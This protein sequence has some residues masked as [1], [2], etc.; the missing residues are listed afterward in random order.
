[1]SI[2]T[3]FGFNTDVKLGDTI[4][5]VQ[6]EARQ[7]DMLLQTLVFVKGQCVGKRAVS[8]AQKTTETDFSEQAMHELLKGQHKT[9]LDAIQQGRIESILAGDSSIQDV[10]EGG[11]TLNWT[12]PAQSPQGAKASMSFQV[13]HEGRAVP[14]ANISVSAS[15]P[16]N[17][18]EVAS[19]TTDA[20]GNATIS[21]SLTEQTMED[22]AVMVRASHQGKS[23]TR[24]F[25]FK[26]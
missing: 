18:P 25:R 23:A 15:L 6:S 19:A 8:Y 4:Y 26:K 9:V 16:A 2:M 20:Q 12:N 21:F 7:R 14:G 10:G 11:L 17:A 22:G 1:M 13:L 3:I 24:K 5:H